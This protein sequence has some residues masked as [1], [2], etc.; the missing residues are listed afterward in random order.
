MKNAIIRW[1]LF[2]SASIAA[3]VCLLG[4]FTIKRACVFVVCAAA[5]YLMSRRKVL[6][7]DRQ[8][9]GIPPRRSSP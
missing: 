3:A 5:W 9:L 8:A 6:S 1:A 7:L 2:F 4:H